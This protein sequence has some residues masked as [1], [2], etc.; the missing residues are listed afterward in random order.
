[1]IQ[2]RASTPKLPLLAMMVGAV[3]ALVAPAS[4]SAE[5]CQSNGSA[6]GSGQL[7]SGFA[8][9]FPEGIVVDHG[10]AFVSGPAVFGTAGK[11]PS[12]IEIHNSTTGASLGV[13]TLAGEVLAQEHALSCITTDHDGALYV[14]STQLGVVRFEQQ[15]AGGP[16]KQDVYAP[17]LPD[18]HPCSGAAPGVACSPTTFDLPPL[19]NDLAFAADGDLY[20]TDSF[21]ATIFRVPA[22]GGV[23]QIWFQSAALESPP[24]Q[25]GTNGIRVSPSGHHLLFTVTAE[26]STNGATGKLYKLPL[27]DAPQQSD[28]KVMHSYTQGEAPDGIA[29]GAYGDLYV[30]LAASNQI[31][32][33]AP[34]GWE[35]GR[36]SGP[37]GSS[38]PLDA[39]ANVAF[40]GHGSLLVTNHAA[41][42]QNAAHFGVLRITANDPGLPLFKPDF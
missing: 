26:L 5:A 35:I 8:P 41:F 6:F 27:V 21:Q 32:L 34:G 13:I 4:G 12:Q 33:L 31:S 22:G 28:L 7:F 11:G 42:S 10:R 25:I 16:W 38:V 36:I 20:I 37:T 2:H 19:S 1:M 30:A 3:A 15:Y 40:D 9:G 23:P 39:P 14:L 24:G 29:Y 18:L 17:P